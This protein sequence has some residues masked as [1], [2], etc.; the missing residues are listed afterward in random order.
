MF[1]T[2]ASISTIYLRFIR[3]WQ[4]R[5]G[6]TDSELA[7]QMAGDEVVNS[8]SFN[9]TRAVTIQARPEHI[10]PWIVQMGVTRAGWYSIDL[11]DNLG[12]P[13]A[14]VILPEFQNPHAGDVIPM[15]PDGKS[16]TYIKDFVPNQWMLWGDKGGD[17]TWVWGLYPIDEMHTR[18]ITRVRVKYHWL[19]PTIIFSML[20]EFTDIM[21]MRKCM[22]GIQ[23]RAQRL[24]KEI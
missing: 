12:K 23:R 1:L 8:P 3:P 17:S 7:R 22:L 18:L 16:G 21:M 4:L 14:E 2:L 13:S 15:S 10:F 11:L 5:W 9:A 24:A 20:V 19:S 6:A